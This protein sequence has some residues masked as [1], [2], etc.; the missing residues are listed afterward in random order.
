MKTLEKKWFAVFVLINL[1]IILLFT[2][3]AKTPGHYGP[4]APPVTPPENIPA[5]PP[6]N[7]NLSSPNAT[8][9]TPST[10]FPI[11]DEVSFPDGAPQL[12][13]EARF[14]R[15]VYAKNIPIKNMRVS[16]NL[17]EGL[18][19]ASGNLTWQGDIVKGEKV[20]IITAVVK[21]VKTG[22]WI[23]DIITDID[24][25]ENGFFIGSLEVPSRGVVY[26]SISEDSA[27]WGLTPLWYKKDGPVEPQPVP[28]Q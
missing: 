26:V 1:I 8:G 12:N 11:I 24:P 18:V 4:S 9:A 27:Q 15:T 10:G 20:D 16:V 17:P 7:Q 25:R 5:K 6:E 21:A 13:H 2:S 22:N 28:S 3:C 14:V 19:L 23:I